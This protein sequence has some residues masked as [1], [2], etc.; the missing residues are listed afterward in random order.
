[1]ATKRDDKPG[2]GLTELIGKALTDKE[3]RSELFAN[4]DAV[5]RRFA[6]SK[7]DTEALKKLDAAKFD[8]ASSQLAG[9]RELTI[10]VSI[11]KSF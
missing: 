8:I 3:L 1:M 2:R 10:K 7:T 4:P 6:L 11:T 9:K 5:A